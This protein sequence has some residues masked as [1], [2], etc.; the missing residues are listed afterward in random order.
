MASE[1]KL[2]LKLEKLK[3][4]LQG[5]EK[6]NES[7]NRIA[8]SFEKIDN[9]AQGQINDG[10]KEFSKNLDVAAEELK[11]IDS[12]YRNT[13][14]SAEIFAGVLTSLVAVLGT[15]QKIT[16]VSVATLD[17]FDRFILKASKS[18]GILGGNFKT[19]STGVGV[20][21]NS[22]LKFSET[23]ARVVNL[24]GSLAKAS[25]V[26][27]K[28]I[29]GLALNTATLSAGFLALGN[30]LEKSENQVV[31]A[32]GQF[33]FFSGVVLGGFSVVISKLILEVG[34][35][36]REVGTTLVN[37]NKRASNSFV[38]LEQKTF[39]FRRTVEGFSKVFGESI[40]TTEKW[41]QT[42]RDVS[43]ATGFTEKALRASVT[44]IIAATSAIGFNEQQM[45]K[46]LEVSVDYAAQIGVDAFDATI[47]FIKAI[48][49]A[50]QSVIK[51]GV[52]LN[53]STVQQKLFS[54][55]LTE[56]F[57]KLSESEKVQAR[58]NA[59]LTQYK[60]IAGV[61][62]DVTE[63]LAGQNKLY[64]ANLIRLSQALGRGIALVENNNIANLALNKIL[65]NVN[66]T[67]VST[68]GF[69]GAL[70]ARLLQIGGAFLEVSF[71]ILIV[72]KVIKLL[73]IFLATTF[74][75]SLIGLPIP[76]LNKSFLDL[77][78]STGATFVS[79]RSLTD[80]IKTFGS[81]AISQIR[82]F[83]AS[84]LGLNAATLTFTK[85]ITTAF[86]KA[87]T[88]AI[89][90]VGLLSKSLLVLAVNPVVITITAIA[91]AAFLLVKGI[92]EL[93][94]QTEVFSTVWK[95]LTDVLNDTKPVLQ[96]ILD[97]FN[98]IKKSI[99][100]IVDKAL[101][102][103]LKTFAKIVRAGIDLLKNNPF[104]IFKKEQL[105]ALEVAEARLTDL[106]IK[107]EKS[108]D[109][110]GKFA[111]GVKKANEQLGKTE[112]AVDPEKLAQL[113]KE[114]TNFGLSD[115]QK[116]QNSFNERQDLLDRSFAQ[117][118]LSQG[119]YN[120]QSALL[121]DQF[122]EKSLEGVTGFSELN[123]ILKTSKR[124]VTELTKEDGSI[125]LELTAL[126]SGV[127]STVAQ[128]A[129]GAQK[130]LSA[131]IA[132]AADT[133]V[134]GLGKAVGPLFDALSAGPEQ[135]KKFT[136]AFTQAIP[137]LIENFILAIPVFIE[138]LA[139]GI[140]DAFVRISERA[141]IIVVEFIKAFVRAAPRIAVG[142]AKSMPT[143]AIAL[144]EEM[145]EVAL[146]FGDELVNQAGRF[147]QALLNEITGA[148]QSD[149]IFGSITGGNGILGGLLGGGVGQFLGGGVGSV[150]GSIGGSFG[151]Q[152]GGFVPGTGSGD[153]VPAMLEP[154]E[155]VVPK[156]QAGSAAS[157]AN[158]NLA[159]EVRETNALL[160]GILGA[161]SS[162][163]QVSTT[164]EI[165]GRK[166]G[167]A[168]LDLNRNN[169]RLTAGI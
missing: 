86:T 94:K 92:Q 74:S 162:G 107:I 77:I 89:R 83:T 106:I 50:S 5:L 139:V 88:G 63:T 2:N 99:T 156:S 96:P 124:L 39:V 29:F 31:S 121:V 34:A 22:L 103:L 101:G 18:T 160:S 20:A 128:G 116:L 27:N 164:I 95:I 140:G 145:P 119:K 65:N 129:K 87:I 38:E 113:S 97:L 26:L 93:E 134:P 21:R 46:L 152:K 71:K 100:D 12:I 25:F 16:A 143:V 132:K 90:L 155:F 44:E 70:A 53:Q 149:G 144:A 102:K 81:V 161:V 169:A 28:G 41:E 1:I 109:S 104:D 55:G 54:N 105:K 3:E 85:V 127:V 67:V 130:L 133:L 35:F 78:K 24:T 59:L 157:L 111:K 43:I 76:F 60:P 120:E 148:F 47:D 123:S 72:L 146:R 30:A 84:L 61:A 52:K 98:D 137:K 163:Q 11:E 165:D 56:N 40:G 75:Q 68:V 6:V 147:I 136:Q 9:Q 4:S 49:G 167:D 42:I 151:F 110:Y 14:K 10:I 7:L 108:G 66:E 19:L 79:F 126:A 142:L 118:L 166:L 80:I 138:E 117:G 62:A 58:Y 135:V 91:A 23:S 150:V 82:L 131:G 15:Q 51:Y 125:T 64:E 154:G 69:F 159:N 8:Q 48:N 73:N 141:D 17:T 158:G 37:A 36:S 153:I 168:I 57:N 32:I 122:K 13:I 114:L 115:A 45:Q 33:T 112:K